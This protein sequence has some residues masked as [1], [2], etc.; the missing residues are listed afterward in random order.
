MVAIPA[1]WNLPSGRTTSV[2]DAGVVD[3]DAPADCLVSAQCRAAPVEECLVEGEAEGH[4]HEPKGQEPAREWQREDGHCFHNAIDMGTSIH[5]AAKRAGRRR[6][7]D[8]RGRSEDEQGMTENARGRRKRL[9]S[10][11]RREGAGA[12]LSRPSG[13]D[14]M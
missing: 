9:A 4:Q 3:F 11:R 14:E 12:E 7:I 1:T 2:F 10:D 5:E 6:A 8:R 13:A